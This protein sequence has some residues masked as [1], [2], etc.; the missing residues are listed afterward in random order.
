[1]GF[2]QEFPS[3]VVRSRD[4]RTRGRIETVAWPPSSRDSASSANRP[5]SWLRDR[6]GVPHGSDTSTGSVGIAPFA[7]TCQAWSQKW[8]TGTLWNRKTWLL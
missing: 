8:S 4:G 6:N 2:E 5:T 1:M 7:P 3:V